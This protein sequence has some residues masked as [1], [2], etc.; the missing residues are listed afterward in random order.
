MKKEY[1]IGIAFG[2]FCT[3]FGIPVGLFF[4][5]NLAY[6][7]SVLGVTLIATCIAV[8]KHNS[9]IGNEV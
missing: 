4:N 9:S 1:I 6:V 2:A 3:G 5:Y 7:V 8:W